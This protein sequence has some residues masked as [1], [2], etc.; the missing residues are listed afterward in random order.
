M[1]R[2]YVTE[3]DAG[4]P[5]EGPAKGAVLPGLGWLITVAL[6]YTLSQFLFVT[7]HLGLGF[8]ESVYT[9]QVSPHA[10]AAFFSAPRARG[11]SFLVAPV[12]ALTYSTTALRCYLMVLSGAGLLGALW[13]WRRLLSDRTLAVAGLVFVSLWI[14]QFYGP[15]VMPNLWVAL[16]ALASVGF[17]LRSVVT[18]HAGRADP[19]RWRMGTGNGLTGHGSLLGVMLCLAAVVQVRPPDG[20]WL[21]LPL[22][23]ASLVVRDWRRP[24]VF[25]ALAIGLIAG[26][27]QW[28]VESYMRYGGI[29]ARLHTSGRVEGGLSWNLAFGDQLK[30]LA[31]RTL[32]RPC[33]VPWRDKADSLWWLAV[34]VVVVLGLYV[35]RRAGRQAVVLVPVFCGLSMAVPY[36]L[37]INYAAPR[38]LLPS[39]ALLALPVGECLVWLSA[40]AGS[41]R[42]R[43]A[44]AVLVV[45]ALAGQLVSQNIV[46]T[47]TV[48]RNEQAHDDFARIAN[49]LREF[50]VT[51]PCLVTGTNAIPIGYA[52]GCASGATSGNNANTTAA[53][54]MR[55]ARHRPVAVLVPR[56]HSVPVYAGSWSPHGMATSRQLG[57]YTV[58]IS[59]AEA[60]HPSGGTQSADEGATRV[61]EAGCASRASLCKLRARWRRRRAG[62][63]AAGAAPPVATA[64]RWQWRTCPVSSS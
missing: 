45:L 46:L 15:Q 60:E 26:G 10:P 28:V 48:A 1:T 27:A 25:W 62:R 40:G 14:T 47:R 16:G 19:D 38:F 44:G 21:V 3:R 53:S 23:V 58:Y 43:R 59:P 52:A 35:A 64:R 39:Y 50:G 17:Y 4:L 63:P 13:V 24:A 18:A 36:L 22:V 5:S 55:T 20:F 30:A 9:S 12:A 56:G 42:L 32:C 6:A 61:E 29:L 8:D 11:I 51:P 7:T 2:S 33:T 49:G 37:L 54:I 57:T 41:P 31:G 34:P